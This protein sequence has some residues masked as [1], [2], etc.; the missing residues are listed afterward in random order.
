MYQ[1]DFNAPA[2]IFTGTGRWVSRRTMAYH[3]FTTG[4]EA[5]R[6]AMEVLGPEMLSGTVMEVSEAR[7]DVAEI[8]TLYESP[9]YPLLRP[10]SC[11]AA[12]H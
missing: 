8:R 2:E 10:G 12:D 5:I 4:A 7:F 9:G 3:R 1:F 6:Y 11:D